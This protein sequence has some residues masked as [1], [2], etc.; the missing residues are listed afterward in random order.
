M[1]LADG[2]P[3][4][5]ECLRQEKQAS[6]KQQDGQSVKQFM[7]G[8]TTV[9]VSQNVSPLTVSLLKEKVVKTVR[10][11]MFPIFLF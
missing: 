9:T 7:I 5:A 1:R 10:F 2:K 8:A 3:I 4:T 6:A 11:I